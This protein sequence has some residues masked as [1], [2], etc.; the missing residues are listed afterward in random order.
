MTLF[1]KEMEFSLCD[2]YSAFSLVSLIYFSIAGTKW[3][4]GKLSRGGSWF[5][6]RDDMGREMS[7]DEMME[8]INLVRESKRRESLNPP[9]NI[10]EITSR[11][12]SGLWNMLDSLPQGPPE[13]RKVVR[14]F[15]DMML[16]QATSELAVPPVNEGELIFN[17][18][19][20][21]V[22]KGKTE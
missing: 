9:A 15:V 17:R 1:T 3:L 4:L 18:F 19:T 8:Q 22:L 12:T 21:M 7:S 16:S 2:F 10:E 6:V 5:P 13:Q 14:S 20:E 11:M